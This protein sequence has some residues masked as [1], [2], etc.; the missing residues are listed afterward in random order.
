MRWISTPDT[1]WRQDTTQEFLSCI[2]VVTKIWLGILLEKV[3]L[4]ARCHN[5]DWGNSVDRPRLVLWW[6]FCIVTCGCNNLSDVKLLEILFFCLIEI[7]RR[8][9]LNVYIFLLIRLDLFKVLLGATAGVTGGGHSS[10][11]VLDYMATL[12]VYFLKWLVNT[13]NSLLVLR[14]KSLL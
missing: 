5:L 11:C 2:D 9:I 6:R 1:C 3:V 13:F 8:L 10:F 12:E 7:L 14:R 4:I